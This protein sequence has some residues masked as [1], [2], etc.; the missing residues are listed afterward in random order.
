VVRAALVA[1]A[2]RSQRA[3][4]NL[5]LVEDLLG[6]FDSLAFDDR[7]ADHAGRIRASLERAGTPVGPNDLLIAAIALA[8]DLTLVTHDSSE[9]A[10]IPSLRIKDWERP[11]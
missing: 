11:T 1:G 3:E 10:R 6:N 7:A 4:R 2:L 9:F 8:H 5:P